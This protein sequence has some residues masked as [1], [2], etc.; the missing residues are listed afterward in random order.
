MGFN[1]GN[2]YNVFQQSSNLVDAF[3]TGVNEF[4]ALGF[5][6]FATTSSNRV[7]VARDLVML[8]YGFF[9][10][11]NTADADETV[12]L[13]D[14]DATASPAQVLTITGGLGSG[15][16][17]LENLT[18]AFVGN[19]RYSFAF[20]GTFGGSLTARSLCVEFRTA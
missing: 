20:T 8:R 2:N 6:T 19:H 14:N 16:Y 5:T 18:Y 10:N 7:N 3:T 9:L 15:F 12:N 4:G 17:I 13:L 11:A 1:S